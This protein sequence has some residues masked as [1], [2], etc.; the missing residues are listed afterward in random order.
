MS[1]LSDAHF[2]HARP[3]SRD[4]M[5]RSGDSSSRSPATGTFADVKGLDPVYIKA[6]LGN[7]AGTRDVDRK[8]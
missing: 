6:D 7:K 1:N 3:G 4:E 2:D 5:S 8:A